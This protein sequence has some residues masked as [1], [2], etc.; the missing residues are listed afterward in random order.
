MIF[1][2]F[3][4]FILKLFQN[5]IIFGAKKNCAFVRQADSCLLKH[6]ASAI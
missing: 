1:F 4:N 5:E 2:A 3:K 6:S